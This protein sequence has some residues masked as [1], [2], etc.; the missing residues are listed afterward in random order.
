MI[1]GLEA[2]LKRSREIAAGTW[3]PPRHLEADFADEFPIQPKEAQPAEAPKA[4]AP[5]V[6]CS[7]CKALCEEQTLT[8]S[9]C[10]RAH[11]CSKACQVR[12]WRSG[13]KRVC[14]PATAFR[15]GQRCVVKGLRSSPELNGRVVV[16]VGP[17]GAAGG[18]RWT[19]RTAA[20]EAGGARRLAVRPEN[21][22]EFWDPADRPAPPELKTPSREEAIET[23]LAYRDSLAERG[24][25]AGV[26]A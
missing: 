16:V 5:P 9:R 18:E 19:V 6:A 15:A 7:E 13:H 12:A 8:C 25:L 20:D 4:P 21:L 3:T 17:S 10:K 23:L 24:P 1:H 11:Y 2:E 14:A 22:M 26:G